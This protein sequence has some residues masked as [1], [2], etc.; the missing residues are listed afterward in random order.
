MLGIQANI[1]ALFYHKIRQV[2]WARLAL[3]SEEILGG[4]IELDA[5]NFDA[6]GGQV[7]AVDGGLSR[8]RKK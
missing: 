7:L 3:Q 2:I 4:E 5:T 8:V 1:A 6:V